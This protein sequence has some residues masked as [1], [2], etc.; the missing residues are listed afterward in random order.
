MLEVSNAKEANDEVAMK[1]AQKK[2][3]AFTDQLNE[4]NPI[5]TAIS[6]AMTEEGTALQRLQDA[7]SHGDAIAAKQYEAQ[8]N[9]A[10]KAKYESNLRLM[11]LN[12]KYK[13]M[14]KSLRLNGIHS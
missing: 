7:L 14:M 12:A 13:E 1:F 3:D 4:S 8:M 5:L 9:A 6:D 2:V 11:E 10:A